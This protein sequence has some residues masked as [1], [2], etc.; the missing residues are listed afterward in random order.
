M[1]LR[2][3]PREPAGKDGFGRV[4]PAEQ[5]DRA[6]MHTQKGERTP[7]WGKCQLCG[8]SFIFLWE[9]VAFLLLD[10][11]HVRVVDGSQVFVFFAVL[12][13]PLTRGSLE[14]SLLH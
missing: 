14:G 10:R 8:L 6:S 12:T 4:T 7:L 9:K 11:G 2:R 13:A 5:K 3:L 1:G